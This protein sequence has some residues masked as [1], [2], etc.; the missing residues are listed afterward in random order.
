M[1]VVCLS[2]K[3]RLSR[4]K[5]AFPGCGKMGIGT[6]FGKTHRRLDRATIT[7]FHFI[8]KSLLK[9]Q[10]YAHIWKIVIVCYS[11][12]YFALCRGPVKAV[13]AKSVE[14]GNLLCNTPGFCPCPVSGAAANKNRTCVR[15]RRR[16]HK[17]LGKLP[18]ERFSRENRFSQIGEGF[19]L[20]FFRQH[21]QNIAQLAE[22][23]RVH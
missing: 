9:I 20:S 12:I 23:F 13:C 7:L 15:A 19:R 5:A 11:Q 4:K 14:N 6:H 18:R 16:V 2:A 10:R 21:L 22:G 8:V 3:C 17:S 1:N